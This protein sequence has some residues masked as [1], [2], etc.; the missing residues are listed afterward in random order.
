M[1]HRCAR[2][3][4]KFRQECSA[5]IDALKNFFAKPDQIHN[6]AD[7]L[8]IL[9]EEVFVTDAPALFMSRDRG[10]RLRGLMPLDGQRSNR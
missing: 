9:L 1:E 10:G 5:R 3:N 4:R 2:P 7:W 6:F 8:R